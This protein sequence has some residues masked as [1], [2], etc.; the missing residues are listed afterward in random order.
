M[1][2][3]KPTKKGL[4]VEL[5]GN[6]DDLTL[7]YE[8]TANL[9]NKESNLNNDGFES[10]DKIISSFSYEVRK[11]YEESRLIS[12]HGYYIFS[13]S[14]YYGCQLSWIH[15]LFVISALRYNTRYYSISE[16]D[17]SIL[18]QLEYWFEKA[19]FS[20]DPQGASVLSNYIKG[21]I[22]SGNPNLYL[23]MRRINAEYFCMPRGKKS[24]RQLPNLLK[25][26]CNYTD[27]YS[28]YEKSLEK[29]A[30]QFDCKI[31]A[32]E[33]ND[34]NVNYEDLQW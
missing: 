3:I 15:L 9:W 23:Y 25:T 34:D 28:T 13:E 16:L 6:Y 21:N 22:Y 18:M 26:A 27:E 19:M 8:V 5:W 2:F 12:E 4:G 20:Y 7:L 29:S 1:L 33:L 30:K 31:S 17:Q 14:K 24:F 11:S 32:L 10:R